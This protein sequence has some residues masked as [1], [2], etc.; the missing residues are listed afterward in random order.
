MQPQIT[1]TTRITDWSS[2][3]ES[4]LTQTDQSGHE[5]ERIW[6]QLT[7]FFAR[8]AWFTLTF[9]NGKR[10][11]QKTVELRAILM[12]NMKGIAGKD[13]FTSMCVSKT[14]VILH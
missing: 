8:E 3:T 7:F 9:K 5:I 11:M 1:S 13:G 10:V 4:S 6:I 2:I 12:E 14:I